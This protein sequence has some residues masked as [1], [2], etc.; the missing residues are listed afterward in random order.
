MNL[1]L[2]HTLPMPTQHAIPPGSVNEYQQKLGSKPGIPRHALALYP[3]SCSF[4]W[5]PAEGYR[6]RR[7]ASSYGPGARE[8][9]YFLINH[10]M[11]LIELMFGKKKSCNY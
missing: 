5:C 3:R 6:K 10:A 4:S 11:H 7:S 9:L 1:S 8:E 2:L